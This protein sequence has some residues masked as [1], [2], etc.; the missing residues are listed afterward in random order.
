MRKNLSKTSKRC[1]TWSNP[2]RQP[3]I[4]WR[5]WSPRSWWRPGGPPPPEPHRRW[6]NSGRP[7]W[8]D[9]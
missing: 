7:D 3:Y 6:W 4:W 1:L 8:R 5:W 2:H 9:D